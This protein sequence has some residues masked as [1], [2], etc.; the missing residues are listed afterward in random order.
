MEE[1]YKPGKNR[2]SLVGEAYG[3]DKPLYDD[4]FVLP[5]QV[6]GVVLLNVLLCRNE[7]V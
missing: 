5:I 6:Q 4:F 7:I 3:D 1:K 2:G